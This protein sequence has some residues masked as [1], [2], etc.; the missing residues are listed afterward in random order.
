MLLVLN[1]DDRSVMFID[2]ASGKIV[3]TL[4][5][6]LNP[7]EAIVSP[8]GKV[9]YVSNAGDNTV[10]IIDLDARQVIGEIKDE[11][12]RFP[13]GLEVTEDGK[14]LW[15][16]ATRSHGIWIYERDPNRPA[17]HE[18][19]KVVP[20][21]HRMSHMVH[22]SPDGG[23][24]YVPNIESGVLTVFDT[25]SMDVINQI[26]VGPGPE[27]VAV[28]PL[29]G[30]IY[31]ANQGDDTL[32]VIDDRNYD[33]RYELTVGSLPV[34]ARF[35]HDGEL[36]LISNRYSHDISVISHRWDRAT[37][38]RQPWEIKRFPV[39]RWPGQVVMAPDGN[40]AWVTNNKTN[41]ISEI[42]LG[43]LTEVRRIPA[44]V[45]PDGMVWIP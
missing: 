2:D 25:R 37:V 14:Y 30:T 21:Q 13:H 26:R 22:L 36:V 10:S 23:R 19:V 8:N 15:V 4:A 33:R 41:D 12:W 40:R 39:G 27:G 18:L 43:T 5:V 32:H 35:T 16:A 38:T 9:A 11:H 28:H 42:D 1:K 20:T 29:D 45:H 31:V 44:G 34:R 24:A 7:H 17:W 6:G 3:K